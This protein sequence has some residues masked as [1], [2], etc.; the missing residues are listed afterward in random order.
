MTSV[1]TLI[2]QKPPSASTGLR[3]ERQ[4][5]LDVRRGV[6]VGSCCVHG[7]HRLIQGNSQS[8]TKNARLNTIT[9][10]TNAA[11]NAAGTTSL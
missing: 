7:G 5:V 2:V 11:K 4:V 3:E 1:S 8:R 10:I 6:Q 9:V